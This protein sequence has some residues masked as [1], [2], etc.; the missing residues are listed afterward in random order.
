MKHNRSHLQP[1]H[2]SL[3]HVLS[4]PRRVSRSFWLASDGSGFMLINQGRRTLRTTVHHRGVQN[5][6]HSSAS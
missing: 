5:R 6:E 3:S 2:D 4:K 1:R